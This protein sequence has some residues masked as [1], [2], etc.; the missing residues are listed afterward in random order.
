MIIMMTPLR[1][2]NMLDI[3]QN[4]SSYKACAFLKPAQVWCKPL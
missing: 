3:I 1:D 4:L 2:K